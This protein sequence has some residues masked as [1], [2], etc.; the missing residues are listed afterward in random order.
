MPDPSNTNTNITFSTCWYQFKA[1]FDFSVYAEWIRNMLSNVRAYNLVIYTDEAGLTAFDFNAYAAVNPR[2]RV[3]IKPFESFRNYAL[4][5][6][7]IANHDKNVLLNKLVD[8]RVNA[9]W[10]EKVHFV[11]E[12]VTQKY[13]D[14]D[15][16]GWCDIGYFRGRTSGSMRDLPMTQL[17]TWPNPAKIAVLNPDK[18]YYGCVNNDW[19]QIDYCIR[20]INDPTQT[21]GVDPRLNFIAGGFFILHKTKAEWWLI[22]YDAKLHRYLSQGRTVKDDQQIIVDCVFSKDTQSNFHI[23]REEGSKYD[24][25]FMFQRTLL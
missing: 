17:R 3:V 9:L 4:K 14:T 13:F 8:W 15:F 2:I 5:D 24:N 25:W 11:N 19:N 20:T 22:T 23:C 18:I 10:S 12:T 7:W 6:L 16:Y 1:K 21:Q